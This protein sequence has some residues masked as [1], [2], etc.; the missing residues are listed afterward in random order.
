M[1]NLILLGNKMLKLT[2][3]LSGRVENFTP[4]ENNKVKMYVCGITPYDSP[5]VGHGRCYIS[6]DLLFRILKFL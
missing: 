3:T 5:H 1:C 6:F 2:N 4:L